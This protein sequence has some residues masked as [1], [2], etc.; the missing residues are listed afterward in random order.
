M[1][2]PVG[3]AEMN[4]TKGLGPVAA[5]GIGVVRGSPDPTNRAVNAGTF[6]QNFGNGINY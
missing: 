5:I 2:G 3:F 4:S 1:S 6:V